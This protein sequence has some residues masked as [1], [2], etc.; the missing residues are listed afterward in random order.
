MFNLQK[1]AIQINVW[2]L[3]GE[4]PFHTSLAGYEGVG[5]EEGIERMFKIEVTRRVKRPFES[6]RKRGGKAKM[7]KGIIEGR[8]EREF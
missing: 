4:R 8:D 3:R 6:T 2:T 7:M 1:E 5:R